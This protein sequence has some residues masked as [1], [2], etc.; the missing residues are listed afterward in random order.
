MHIDKKAT[1]K[2]VVDKIA[3][4][5]S[6]G[7]EFYDDSYIIL[8]NIFPELNSLELS[9]NYSKTLWQ[10]YWEGKYELAEFSTKAAAIA[11]L[12]TWINNWVE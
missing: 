10:L 9:Y 12:T 1:A 3:A 4:F 7:L 8:H 2:I 11:R 6:D 5:V